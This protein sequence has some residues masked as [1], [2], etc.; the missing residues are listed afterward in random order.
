VVGIGVSAWIE[1]LR[2]R[3]CFGADRGMG[4]LY[5]YSSK[6]HTGSSADANI[7]NGGM[8]ADN[9]SCAKLLRPSRDVDEV[10]SC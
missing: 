5:T 9:G 1:I 4:C 8:P 10:L 6:P 2:S 7:K 3:S